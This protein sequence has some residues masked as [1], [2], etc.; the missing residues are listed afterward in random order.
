MT[1]TIYPVI[2]P[3]PAAARELTPKGRTAFLSRHAREA[4]RISAARAGIELGPLEKD[5]RGAPRPFQD[6]FWS[7]THK[8]DYVGGVVAPSAVGLDL[9]KIRPCA[10]G[11]F[12][13]TASEEEWS[14]GAGS[15]RQLLFFRYWTAKE[16]VL[17][18]GG[19]GMRD[20]SRCRI[21][22]VL[23]EAYLLVDYAGHTWTVEQFFFDGHA[24]S[25]AARGVRAEWILLA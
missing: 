8:P 13:R 14:L 7:L 17:K 2:L 5:A 11:L 4:L 1:P 19:E 23:D 3:V 6:R 9:E 22:Q 15:D 24:A 12:R 18:S 20:L 10:P 21:R 25:L 16:A